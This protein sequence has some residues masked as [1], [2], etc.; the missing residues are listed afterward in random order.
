MIE[1]NTRVYESP[2]CGDC[3]LPLWGSLEVTPQRQVQAIVRDLFDRYCGC[4]THEE[5]SAVAMLAL[6]ERDDALATFRGAQ[7]AGLI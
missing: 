2:I 3:E 7:V 4:S 1:L 6:R 5:L